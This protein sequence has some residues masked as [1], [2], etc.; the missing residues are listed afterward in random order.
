MPRFVRSNIELLRC[1]SSFSLAAY[2]T[3]DDW[4]EP[5][6]L[7]KLQLMNDCVDTTSFAALFETRNSPNG[8][9]YQACLDILPKCRKENNTKSLILVITYSTEPRWTDIIRWLAFWTQSLKELP[10]RTNNL[11]P[12]IAPKN[13][14]PNNTWSILKADICES[15]DGYMSFAHPVHRSG[16]HTWS[17]RSQGR[18]G[19]PKVTQAWKIRLYIR[20]FFCLNVSWFVIDLFRF[21]CQE[22]DEC[23][24]FQLC[25]PNEV[26][27]CIV[28]ASR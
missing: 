8:L 15:F 9:S 26:S 6:Y 11:I 17:G 5:V 27:K 12:R 7:Q 3:I 20:S 22:L 24:E 23:H 19:R 21:R 28:S 18:H 1:S 4:N 10:G 16:I 14:A 2:P 25:V 13:A